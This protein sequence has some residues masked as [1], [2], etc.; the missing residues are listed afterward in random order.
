ME[1]E[2]FDKCK[3]FKVFVERKL[4]KKIFDFEGTLCFVNWSKSGHNIL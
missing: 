4:F 1:N 2:L 3:I